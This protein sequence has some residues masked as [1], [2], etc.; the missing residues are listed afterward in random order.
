MV[1][2]PGYVRYIRLMSRNKAMTARVDCVT[3]EQLAIG[4]AGLREAKRAA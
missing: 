1:E 4:L 3:H 2:W